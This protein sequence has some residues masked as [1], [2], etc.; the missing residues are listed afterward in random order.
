MQFPSLPS[1]SG[2]K[3]WEDPPNQP[4]TLFHSWYKMGPPWPYYFR[5]FIPSYTHLIT[6]M[7]FHRVCWGFNYLITRVPAPS[8]SHPWHR[9]DAREPRGSNDFRSCCSEDRGAKER[10]GNTTC[11]CLCFCLEF[12]ITYYLGLYVNIYYIHNICVYYLYTVYI[13]IYIFII[14]IAVLRTI[15]FDDLWSNIENFRWNAMNVWVKFAQLSRL[16][17]GESDTFLGWCHAAR[18]VFVVGHGWHLPQWCFF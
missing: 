6:T 17:P 2:E 4:K 13:Y 16:T 1:T 12:W 7:V 9:N 14:Y 15:L 5:G 8:S 3:I 18:D 10:F 11:L